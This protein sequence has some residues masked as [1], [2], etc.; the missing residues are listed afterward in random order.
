MRGQKVKEPKPVEVDEVEEWKVEKILNK[1]KVQGIDKYLVRWKGFI[2]ENNTWEKE[3]DLKNAKEL[4]NEF[5]GRLEAEVKQQKRINKRW[6]IKLNPNVKEFKRSE[7]P[8]KYTI[9]ILY[10]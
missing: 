7:L 8:E 5:E 6:K 3:E 1:R 10:E 2:V 4:V 9:K